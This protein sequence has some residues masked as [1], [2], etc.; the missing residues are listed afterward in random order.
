MT[1]QEILDGMSNGEQFQWL[2]PNNKWQDVNYKLVFEKLSVYYQD[3]DIPYI[4]IKSNFIQ[5][6]DDKIKE[7]KT[8]IFN[9]EDL[10]MSHTN[11][12]N[13]YLEELESLVHTAFDKG[14][15]K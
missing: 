6:F 3:K 9:E 1:L 11:T 5:T 8:Y 7:V 4:R 10:R 2:Y 12:I 13:M 15:I 14:D